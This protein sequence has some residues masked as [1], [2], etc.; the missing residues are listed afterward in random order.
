MDIA[1]LIHIPATDLAE[2]VHTAEHLLL[3]QVRGG[4]DFTLLSPRR[5]E[6][7]TLHLTAGHALWLPAGYRHTVHVHADSTLLPT[8]YPVTSTATRLAG[9]V[10][11]PVDEVLTSLILAQ[12]QLNTTAIQPVA[13]IARQILALIEDAPKITDSLPTPTSEPARRIADAIRFNPG[14]DRSAAELAA[15]VHTSLRS[16]QRHFTAETGMNLQQWRTRARLGAGAELL[17]DGGNLSAVANRVGYADVSS[18]CRA[19][20]A[21]YGVPTREYLKRYAMSVTV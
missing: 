1:D 2:R 9:P 8:F 11:V 18:F 17:R 13:N 16:V 20:K 3:W 5:Q 6:E 19:F 14:D 21:H 7:Q 10:V 15:S 4:S 12:I